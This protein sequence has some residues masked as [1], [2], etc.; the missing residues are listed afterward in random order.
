M[1]RSVLLGLGATLAV[2]GLF[3][4]MGACGGDAANGSGEDGGVA[5]PLIGTWLV[6]NDEDVATGQV[7]TI[8]ADSIR[9]TTPNLSPSEGKAVFSK[10]DGTIVAD[11]Y[12]STVT[13]TMLDMVSARMEKGPGGSEGSWLLH[14]KKQ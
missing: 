12:G 1:R 7:V 2:L 8:T 11:W 9:M 13:F 6:V 10:G 14:R 4:T 5:A 3:T